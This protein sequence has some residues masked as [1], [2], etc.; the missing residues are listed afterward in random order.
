MY[1]LGKFG[2][3]P[4]YGTQYPNY[5]DITGTATVVLDDGQLLAPPIRTVTSVSTFP[6]FEADLIF[7]TD[8]A[9]FTIDSG[10]SA[11]VKVT[12]S[13]KGVATG[14]ASGMAGEAVGLG[15]DALDDTE[16]AWTEI[17]D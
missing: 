6:A 5:G 4:P 9:I 11:G 16:P 13:T 10:A 15:W 12:F 2:V 7:K 8:N 3:G 17:K 1:G 14:L